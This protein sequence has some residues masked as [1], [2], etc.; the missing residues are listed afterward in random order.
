MFA[1]Y[2]SS[3]KEIKIFGK[4]KSI[5]ADR[6]AVFMTLRR[7]QTWPVSSYNYKLGQLILKLSDQL[8]MAML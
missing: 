8:R 4:E 3:I 6:F 2:S 1:Y 5:P 7:F